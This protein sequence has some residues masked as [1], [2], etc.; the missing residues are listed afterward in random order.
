M[1]RLG[2]S[3]EFRYEVQYVTPQIALMTHSELT[4]AVDGGFETVVLTSR[5]L[6]EHQILYNTVHPLHTRVTNGPSPVLPEKG[7]NVSAKS[8][9]ERSHNRG[10]SEMLVSW[11]R[12]LKELHGLYYSYWPHD[13]DQCSSREKTSPLMEATAWPDAERGLVASD[14][15]ITT[16]SSSNS[17]PTS[18]NSDRT[19]IAVHFRSW[20]WDFMPPDAIKPLAEST[21]GD[22]VVLAQRL[23]MK[24]RSLNLDDGIMQADGNGFALNA[25][26][27]KG[28]GMVFKFSAVGKIDKFPRIVPSMAA[29]KLLCGLLPGDP[30]L[31]GADFNLVG[32]DREALLSHQEGGLFD[33]LGIAKIIIRA[34]KETYL[35]L[36]QN[37]PLMLLMPFL[38]QRDSNIVTVE[39]R[40]MLDGRR[41]IFSFWEGRYA[42]LQALRHRVEHLPGEGSMFEVKL[43]EVL[44]HFEDMEKYHGDFY[45]KFEQADITSQREMPDGSW[46]DDPTGKGK[47]AMVEECR[48]K[49]DWITKQFLD[50]GL[51]QSS[52]D[53]TL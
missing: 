20:T 21:I 16:V 11:L 40:G 25:T 10:H 42:L 47:K 22:I 32:N 46:E 9:L 19:D 2:C 35:P 17:Q 4:D 38:P 14:H 3:S 28:L 12:L 5:E 53:R 8:L 23:G 27:T 7:S 31:V 44:G 41:S 30:V 51:G 18:S 37:E 48:K 34:M 6:K 15:T 24:W 29:D 39:I 45:I 50:A 26:E 13:C 52:G 1:T 33:K 36:F 49:F 43:K